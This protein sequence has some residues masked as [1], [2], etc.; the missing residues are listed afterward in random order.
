MKYILIMLVLIASGWYQPELEDYDYYESVPVL[1]YSGTALPDDYL[2]GRLELAIKMEELYQVPV[3]VQIA[4]DIIESGVK[5]KNRYHKYKNDSWVVCK[6]NYNSKT[7]SKHSDNKI[8]FRAYDQY[9]GNY[10][11]F[12]KYNTVEQGWEDKAR[13]IAS[14]KWF[15]PNMPFEYYAKHLQGTYAESKTYTAALKQVKKQYVNKLEYEILYI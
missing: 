13:I 6:C 5:K 11:Y 4:V 14:Y 12:K 2:N 7:R 15:K 10:K 3:A 8:C 1:L 9:V